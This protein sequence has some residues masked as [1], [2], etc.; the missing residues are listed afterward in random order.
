VPI[1][2]RTPI[3]DTALLLTTEAEIVEN[4]HGNE[5]LAEAGEPPTIEK[6]PGNAE[7]RSIK[8]ASCQ[9]PLAETEGV[10]PPRTRETEE[11]TREEPVVAS[12]ITPTKA[13]GQNDPEAGSETCNA[14]PAPP[15]DDKC[16]IE[17]FFA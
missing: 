9:G 3:T 10:G 13:A 16:L 1:R 14:A 6:T 7:I 5:G 4:G 15:E 12:E 17:A 11:L 8:E 2:P